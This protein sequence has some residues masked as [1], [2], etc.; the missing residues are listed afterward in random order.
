MIL[1]A[2][3]F[4]DRPRDFELW[5][6]LMTT[7]ATGLL[8]TFG[9]ATC[10]Y[11]AHKYRRCM[12]GYGRALTVTLGH[13]TLQSIIFGIDT[14]LEMVLPLIKAG[15]EREY[16]NRDQLVDLGV[17]VRSQNDAVEPGMSQSQLIQAKKANMSKST[18]KIMLISIFNTQ[19]IVEEMFESRGHKFN[20]QFHRA[21]LQRL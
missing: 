12:A 13:R 21:V 2:G 5:D 20:Q 9:Q 18:F 4:G 15:L 7:C 3:L 11:P 6:L 19:G 10:R 8:P 16:W 14:A 17:S 1:L